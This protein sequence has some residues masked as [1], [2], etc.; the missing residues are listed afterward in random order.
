ML[1]KKSKDLF[2]EVSECSVLAEIT[3][4]LDAPFTVESIQESPHDDNADKVRAF[5]TLL[6]ENLNWI[7]QT[8]SRSLGVE[9]LHLDYPSWL[10]SQNISVSEDV[11]LEELDSRWLSIFSLMGNYSNSE[12]GAN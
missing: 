11:Q 10:Q 4:S 6:P 1:T 2:F 7:H 3:S 9:V 5:V 8:L 12:D